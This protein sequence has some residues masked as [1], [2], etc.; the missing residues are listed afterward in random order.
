[1]YITNLPP[2]SPVSFKFCCV[3]R[4]PKSRNPITK[5]RIYYVLLAQANESESIHGV[6]HVFSDSQQIRDLSLSILAF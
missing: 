3:A 5:Y 2:E 4:I 1:M 6:N